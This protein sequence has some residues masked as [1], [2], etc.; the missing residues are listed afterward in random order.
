MELVGRISYT[1]NI[2]NHLAEAKFGNGEW[3]NFFDNILFDL[4]KWS[5]KEI[6]TDSEEKTEDIRKTMS[7]HKLFIL[8]NDMI[9]RS[10]G[11][12]N[13]CQRWISG[14]DEW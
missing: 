6:K 14:P 2:F 13:C 12:R 1:S 10:N 11:K 5:K 4:N 7:Q 3:V 9:R 8:R